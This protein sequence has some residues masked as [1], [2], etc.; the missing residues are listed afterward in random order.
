MKNF[1]SFPLFALAA[2]PFALPL[3]AQIIPES[4]IPQSYK[5]AELQGSA[6]TDKWLMLN[7][8]NYDNTVYQHGGAW[9]RA[10]LPNAPS[11]GSTFAFTKG[12][13]DVAGIGPSDGAVATM[14]IYTKSTI[15]PFTISSGSSVLDSIG[16]IA[17][18]AY[19][20]TGGA[21]NVIDTFYD[22][23]GDFYNMPT[24][25]VYGAGGVS[26]TLQISN[27]GP[28]AGPDPLRPN[29]PEVHLPE[30]YSSE[31]VTFNHGPFEVTQYENKR[32]FEW[33]VSVVQFDIV[34]FDIDFALWEHVVLMSM[35]VDQ[36][37]AVPEPS[38]I[39]MLLGAGAFAA[40]LL[41]RRRC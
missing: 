5:L 6:R 21:N 1:I 25:T 3:S 4:E 36:F 22:I 2:L 17:F 31:V 32:L 39:V 34:S 33:D 10:M 7:Q 30:P 35:Q 18:Q 23:N 37:A 19:A 11:A 8:D 26:Q 9:P 14:G 24:L 16:K 15:T 27:A 13:L 40:A 29:A 41:R 38:T 28:L 12:P 20:R